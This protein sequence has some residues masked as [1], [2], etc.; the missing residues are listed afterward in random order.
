M[1]RL[2]RD[3]ARRDEDD[4]SRFRFD[5]AAHAGRSGF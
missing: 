5:S 3:S 4:G 1:L 2:Y